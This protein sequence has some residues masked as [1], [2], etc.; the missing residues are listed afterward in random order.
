MGTTATL[1]VLGSSW[2]GVVQVTVMEE[3]F[4]ASELTASPLAGFSKATVM[5]GTLPSILW[6][7]V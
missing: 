1:T 6:L 7:P 3:S 4:V 5:L 2:A